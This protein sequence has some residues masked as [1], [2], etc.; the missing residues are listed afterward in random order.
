M[1]WTGQCFIEP[2][3][4]VAKPCIFVSNGA[5]ESNQCHN[6][7]NYKPPTYKCI[8]MHITGTCWWNLVNTIIQPL[9]LQSS[10]MYQ[11]VSG[12]KIY[13]VDDTLPMMFIH[14]INEHL[15]CTIQYLPIALAWSR[16][17]TA[18]SV[19][20]DRVLLMVSS[21]HKKSVFPWAM[22]D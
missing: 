8:L 17:I 18:H 5:F 11:Y 14:M 7:C 3:I 19:L 10:L 16:F 15:F 6:F 12:Q 20:V 4:C 21:L 22:Q 1:Y 13:P 9:H 2:S